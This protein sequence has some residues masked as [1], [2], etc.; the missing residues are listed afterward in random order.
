MKTLGLILL[1][2]LA[3]APAAAQSPAETPPSPGAHGV[4]VVKT[5]WRKQT[6]NPALMEDPLLASD[7]TAQLLRQRKEITRENNERAKAGIRLRPLP[8]QAAGEPAGSPTAPPPSDPRV[9]YLYEVKVVNSG[10][11]KIRSLVWEYVLFDPAT[12]REVGRHSFETKAGI[13]VGKGQTLSGRSGVPPAAVIDVGQS[14]RETR[15]QFAERV[16]ILRVVYE[17]GSVW[18]RERK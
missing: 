9:S 1:S 8:T 14:D 4:S 17:G 12:E 13:G 5:S 18:E 6:F 10:T 16:E 2:L 15:G 11:K 3:C 7:N